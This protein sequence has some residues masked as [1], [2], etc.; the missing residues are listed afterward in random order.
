MAGLGRA[1]VMVAVIL[2]EAG[3]SALDA[4][5]FIRSR[6]R[7]AL[8]SLQLQ[9]LVDTYKRRS[10]KPSGLFSKRS[11]SPDKLMGNPMGPPAATAAYPGFFAK[12]LGKLMRLPPPVA[13]ASL[14]PTY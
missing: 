7:G 12:M 9:W 13:T 10:K 1:P 2:I 4:V 3:M 14:G 8:N 11:I 6:R 5:T